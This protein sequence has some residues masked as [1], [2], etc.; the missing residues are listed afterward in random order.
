MR[1]IETAIESIGREAFHADFWDK[2]VAHFPGGPEQAAEARDL[3]NTISSFLDRTDIR[4]PS[5]RLVKDG[6]EIPL[7]NYT[8]ELRLGPHVS[9][10]WIVN[11][12][13]FH[14]YLQ[15]GTIVLQMLQNSLPSYG[16]IANH[17]EQYF[18]ANIHVSCFITPPNAQGF[19]AHYDTYSFF[20]VQIVGKKVWSLY[21]S[22]LHLPIRD[23]RE[24]D[25]SWHL[26]APETELEMQTGDVLYVPRGKYHSAQTTSAASVHVSIGVFSPNW[27]DAARAALTELQSLPD[28]RQ[29]ISDFS[30]AAMRSSEAGEFVRSHLDVE[31]GAAKLRDE[32]FAK[33]V[34]SRSGRLH[35]L[36]LLSDNSA[37]R[38]FETYRFLPYRLSICGTNAVLRFANKELKFP[39][40]V[41]STLIVIAEQRERFSVSELSNTLDN[42]SMNVLLKRLVC[43]GFLHI[44]ET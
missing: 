9:H 32:V 29:A 19:T 24:H 21:N 31:L 22:T 42:Q 13:V 20:A 16:R 41:Y 10:D 8:R 3:L 5:L 1:A 26:V 2:A 44:T 12:L 15:G 28:L 34:D 4:Y 17:L 38:T 33:H 25:E 43:E 18:G 6:K 30:S 37:M 7:E 39:A 11:E 14:H 36:L 27:I 23:D 40:F 35:D